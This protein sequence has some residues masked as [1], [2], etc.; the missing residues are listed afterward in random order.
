MVESATS[1]LDRD[2]ASSC[3]QRELTPSL[4]GETI[5][6]IQSQNRTVSSAPSSATKGRSYRPSLSDRLTQSLITSGLVR[7]TTPKS[8]RKQCGAQ[9]LDIASSKLGGDVVEQQKAAC[10]SLS[11]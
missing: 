10:S 8:I 3:G 7:G 11:E 5:S 9:I 6:T 2:I 4:F 1:S